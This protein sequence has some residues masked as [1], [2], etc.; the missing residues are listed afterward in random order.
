[1]ARP[2]NT[3]G[4]TLNYASSSIGFIEH[5]V[6]TLST[7]FPDAADYNYYSN[8]ENGPVDTLD[9]G[10]YRGNIWVE[11]TSPSGTTS[12]IMPYRIYDVT[13]SSFYNFPL[14]SV[15]F[16]GEDPRGTWRLTLRNR[17]SFENA[18]IS[19]T[20]HSISF[21]GT[22]ETPQS[23]SRIPAQC[24]PRCDASRGCAAAGTQYCDACAVLRNAATLECIDACPQGFI[25][26]SGYC[27]D[28]TVPEVG[29]VRGGAQVVRSMS[30]L[31][32]SLLTVVG[33]LSIRSIS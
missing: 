32:L 27:Y 2:N 25:Q 24:D 26:R 12:I 6:V 10:P 5:V 18:T 31:M 30:L 22:S 15:H 28:D 19:V 17:N 9:S 29:C 7:S 11:L 13:T 20:V 4:A 1:M 8:E 3:F 16:W 33:W 23:V 21:Y 14:T